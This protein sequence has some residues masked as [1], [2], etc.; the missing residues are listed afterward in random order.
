M[1]ES[2]VDKLE[3]RVD[4]LDQDHNGLVK[5]LKEAEMEMKEG[6]EGLNDRLDRIIMVL[7]AGTFSVIV[8]FLGVAFALLTG[9]I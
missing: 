3:W 1:P 5:D 2:R 4:R 6:F 9:K 7:L 8:F